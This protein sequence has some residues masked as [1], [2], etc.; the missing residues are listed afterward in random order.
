[1]ASN[2]YIIKYTNLFLNKIFNPFNYFVSISTKRDMFHSSIEGINFILTKKVKRKGLNLNVG[3]GNYLIDGFKNLDFYSEGYYPN[4]KIFL[5]ER[6]EYDIRS[7]NIPYKDNTVDNIYCC[8]V[9]EH[10]ETEY[11][12]KFFKESFRVLKKGGVLRIVCPDSEFLYSVL[13]FK[14]DWLNWNKTQD[15]TISN[16]NWEFFVEEM[17]NH[18]L[19]LENYGLKYPIETYDYKDL[20]K[21]LRTNPIFDISNVGKHINNWDFNRLASF[22]HKFNFSKIINSKSGGCISFEMQGPDIDTYFKEFSVCV[23][24]LK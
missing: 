9:V 22:G 12:E 17:A 14:N 7:Q 16:S 19:N 20:L 2:N 18:K 10:I 13:S 24:F 3:C 8:H 15:H 11:V 23:D 5:K 21:E 6:I 1:M 4:K